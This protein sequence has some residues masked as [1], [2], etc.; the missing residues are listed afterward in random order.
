MRGN[1]KDILNWLRMRRLER[2]MKRLSS[3]FSRPKAFTSF[4]ALRTSLSTDMAELSSSFTSCQPSWVL[5]LAER[6]STMSAGEMT[7]AM[8]AK[9]QS[10][11][12]VT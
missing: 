5:R 3:S 11:R 12:A 2:D 1:L 9:G 8:S 7:K 10:M 4:T 6:E